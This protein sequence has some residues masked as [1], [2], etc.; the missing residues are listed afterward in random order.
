MPGARCRV[1]ATREQ[2]KDNK[3]TKLN[4]DNID[5]IGSNSSMRYYQMMWVAAHSMAT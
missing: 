2:I 5:S 1:V 3:G 4:R